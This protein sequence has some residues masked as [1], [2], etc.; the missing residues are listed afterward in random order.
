MS[1]LLV[2]V[3]VSL[4]LVSCE[5]QTQVSR[6]PVDTGAL[7]TDSLANTSPAQMRYDAE[8]GS[9]VWSTE[10]SLQGSL[11]K[12]II[13]VAFF[14]DKTGGTVLIDKADPVVLVPGEKKVVKHEAK[15]L[16]EKAA[17]IVGWNIDMVFE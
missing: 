17:R 3:C 15:L 14:Q 9:L 1:K 2:A 6:S 12:N 4:L 8:R 7:T 10:V 5:E 13:V 16:K 11:P